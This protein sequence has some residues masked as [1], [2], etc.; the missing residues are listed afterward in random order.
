MINH[1]YKRK[2]PSPV[3]EGRFSVLR[4]GALSLMHFGRVFKREFSDGLCYASV[5]LGFRRSITMADWDKL[6]P[7]LRWNYA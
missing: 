7:T 2:T 3:R 6:C 4:L 1:R 5:N